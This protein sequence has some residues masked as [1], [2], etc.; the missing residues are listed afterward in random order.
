ME[1]STGLF[2]KT[3]SPAIVSF[4]LPDVCMH[5]SDYEQMDTSVYIYVLENIRCI[6][7]NIYTHICILIS[8]GTRAHEGFL[9]N[10]V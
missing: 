2:K 3:F 8:Y 6:Y 9:V 1:F 4:S 5:Y 10:K 7:A